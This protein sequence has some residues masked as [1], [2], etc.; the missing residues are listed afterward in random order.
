MA[1]GPHSAR[2]L[3][4]TRDG[5]WNPDYL[6]LLAERLNLGSARDV[7]DVGCG[8]GHFTRVVERMA[9]H[10]RITGL[11]P[12]PQ[13]IEA[14]QAAL[15]HLTFVRGDV[16]ALPFPD[17]SFDVVTCQTVLMHLPD[18]P[19]ALRE[20]WRVLRPGGRVLTM[21]PNNLATNLARL[22][23]DPEF[24]AGDVLA[25]ASLD[26]YSQKG[27]R[28]LGSGYDSI[29]ESL[30]GAL[31]AVGFEEVNAWVN[32]RCLVHVR[33]LDPVA[34]AFLNEDRASAGRDELVWPKEDTRR[35]F[36]AGG[37]DPGA[38]E[39]LWQRAMRAWT[40]RLRETHAANEGALLYVVTGV[41]AGAPISSGL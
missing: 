28:A 23:S 22:V 4:D 7:L 3:S 9:P 41:K 37:G 25:F 29:G 12:E 38:F 13:W 6:R 31:S 16:E 18:V 14:S 24:D 36:V 1:E 33:P 21:E 32:D 11:D 35:Y 27:K 40:R 5:W 8:K 2:L 20:I 19:A 15:P 26:I 39:G 30:S 34:Q 17:A 10:A